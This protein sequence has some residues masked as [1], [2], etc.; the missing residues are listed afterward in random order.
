MLGTQ[1]GVGRGVVG[2]RREETPLQLVFQVRKG[3]GGG[4]GV[5]EGHEKGNRKMI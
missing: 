2:R 4:S 3:C 5:V 1:G